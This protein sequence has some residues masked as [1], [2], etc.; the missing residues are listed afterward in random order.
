MSKPA[1][2]PGGFYLSDDGNTSSGC[3]SC[4]VR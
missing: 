1:N 3:K 4:D 2:C